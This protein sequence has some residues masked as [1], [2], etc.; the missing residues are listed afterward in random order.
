MSLEP[1]HGVRPTNAA[2]HLP[3]LSASACCSSHA[4]GS[5]KNAS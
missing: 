4:P 5:F 2:V 3:M 1:S